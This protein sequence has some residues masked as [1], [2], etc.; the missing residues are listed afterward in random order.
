MKKIKIHTKN[1]FLQKQVQVQNRKTL[2][3]Y[4]LEPKNTN[5]FN[6]VYNLKNIN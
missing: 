1:T 4:C 3:E 5:I 6:Y 2:D